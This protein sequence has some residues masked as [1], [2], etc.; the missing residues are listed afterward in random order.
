MALSSTFEL[1]HFIYSRISHLHLKV[2]QFVHQLYNCAES[3]TYLSI[4]DEN[5]DRTPKN[6]AQSRKIIAKNKL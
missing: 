4:A 5:H 6:K 2:N 1:W 3:L